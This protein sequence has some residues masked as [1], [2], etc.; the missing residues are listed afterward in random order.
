MS[1]E[2]FGVLSLKTCYGYFKK[3]PLYLCRYK[4]KDNMYESIL[5]PYQQ[6]H[7][8]FYKHSLEMYVSFRKNGEF[9]SLE[10]VFG[11]VE[12]EQNFF[13]INCPCTIYILSK[14]NGN[15]LFQKK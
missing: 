13:N 14:N 9:G 2:C 15:M 6:K 8:G 4:N 11:H 12:D 1:E 10:K 7:L 3:K 5:I